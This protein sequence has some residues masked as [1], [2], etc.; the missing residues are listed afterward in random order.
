M[1]TGYWVVPLSRPLFTCLFLHNASILPYL[2]LF[3]S[4]WSVNASYQLSE[5]PTHPPAKGKVE[6]RAEMS[7]RSRSGDTGCRRNPTELGAFDRRHQGGCSPLACIWV[8]GGMSSSRTHKL[9][10]SWVQFGN[11]SDS[12]LPSPDGLY[13]LG[14]PTHH[15]L[16]IMNACFSIT[17][18]ITFKWYV[19]VCLNFPNKC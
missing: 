11:P 15:I 8:N 16:S 17:K 10:I 5:K 2:L 12:L 14:W 7:K 13:L 3:S 18:E 19:S 6:S 9:A 4:S 1:T